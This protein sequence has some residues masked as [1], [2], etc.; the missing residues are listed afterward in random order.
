MAAVSYIAKRSLIGGV[1]VDDPIDL[2]FSVSKIDRSTKPVVG[3]M[4]SLS[5]WQETMRDRTDVFFAVLTLPVL[6][7]DFDDFQQFLDSVDGGELFTFDPYGTIAVPVDAQ[8]CILASK[9]YK[10]K[11][12][13]Q[14]YLSVSFKVRV[15]P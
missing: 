4:T 2:D 14:R 7:A 9:G 11:R 8:Q 1:S 6:A 13:S 10:E 3:S 12:V 5:G 15:H